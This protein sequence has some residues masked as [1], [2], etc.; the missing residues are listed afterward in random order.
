MEKLNDIENKL[1]EINSML[2]IL[3]GYCDSKCE[4]SKEISTMVIVLDIITNKHTEITRA[5]D[6][7]SLETDFS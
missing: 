5:L 1:I 4:Y 2:E 6:N 7:L 3:K